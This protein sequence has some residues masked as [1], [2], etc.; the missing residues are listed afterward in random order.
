MLPEIHKKKT[1]SYNHGTRHRHNE[2]ERYSAIQEVLDRIST[3]VGYADRKN[4]IDTVAERLL[5]KPN[6]VSK[7]V[8]AYLQSKW[9][10]QQTQVS[11]ARFCK[12]NG[13]NLRG[14]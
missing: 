11:F 12:L 9:V 10:D 7:W 14:I 6:T 13:W 3:Q 4:I 2:A 8:V 5:V 1:K